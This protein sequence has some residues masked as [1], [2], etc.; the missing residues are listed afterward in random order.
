MNPSATKTKTFFGH[1]YPLSSLF[2]TEMW[3]RFS[4]YGVRPLLILFMSAALLQGGMGLPIEQASAIVGIFAGG[5]Y[6]TSLP[7]GWLADN[8]L[9]QRRAVW[10]GSLI[11]A[12]GHLSIAMSAIWTNTFFFVGLLLIVLGTGLFKTC[13]TVMV[14]TLYKKEDTRRDGGFSLFYMGIN[15][16]SFIAPLII[17][18]LHEKYGWHIGFGLGGIG[19]L[20]ALLVFRFYAIPQMRRYDKEVGLDST[21]NRPTVERKNVGKWVTVAMALLA[22]LVILIDNGTIPFNATTIAKSS[23]Y[24]ISTCVGIYFVFMFF[25]AG[26]NSSERSRLLACLILL[27]AAAFFWS[28]FEQKPTSFNIFARD[29][30]DR[31]MGSFE[32]P[33]I[34]F[35]AINA[36]FII[37]LA[38]IFSWFWPSLAKRD[39]NPSSMTKFVIGILFAAGGFAVMMMAA[40]QVLA[41]ETGVSP[42][43]LVSSILLL[44]LG[45]LCL[46]PIGLATMTLLAPQKMRGQVMG[47]WFCASAL[48]NLAAGIMGGN[49]SKDQLN[50]MPEL[51]SHVSIALVIC[52]IVLA[53]LIIPVRKMLKNADEN[54]AKA[55]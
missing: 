34:W 9:G 43:W 26:L 52:A 2:L 29:Y 16:G 1:P 51:F 14:G 39:L 7:G 46:S 45:E 54:E 11:I 53:A 27:V 18:P 44:T 47:L 35:Q 10:Y 40:N 13:I 28:A 36:L 8:W 55:N 17:G 37:L 21:W 12:L 5:V 24:I 19:M 6:I 30:T 22:V 41:T 20:I 49:I 3:E 50:S 42:F 33:T 23:A 15:M 4:F 25:F 38:P 31:Q 32:I 48:G